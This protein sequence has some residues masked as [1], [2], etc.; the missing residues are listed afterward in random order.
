MKKPQYNCVQAIDVGSN[1]AWGVVAKKGGRGEVE[2][3][4]DEERITGLGRGSFGQKRLSTDGMERAEQAIRELVE[5][6]KRA[7]AEW[8]GAFGTS[9]LREAI[10]A[11]EFIRRFDGVVH[12][13]RVLSG[14]EE[15]MLAFEGA[16]MML[17]LV[18]SCA[19][20]DVG[21]GSTEVALGEAKVE[22]V[23]SLP[24][25]SLRLHEVF[26]RKQPLDDAEIRSLS[27]AIDKELDCAQIDSLPEVVAISGTAITCGCVARGYDHKDYPN[28]HGLTVER[29]EL[30][31]MACTF[32]KRRVEEVI[33]DRRVDPRRA[34]YFGVGAMILS[35]I[36]RRSKFERI[37]VSLGGLRHAIAKRV[38][39]GENW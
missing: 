4:V 28:V 11:D 21:G 20:V 10:N 38:L 2:V 32:L 1:A 15:G 8:V 7:G 14:E 27:A 23:W 16:R 9:A 35:R 19:V 13:F 17:N 31:E 29:E 33:S 26:V 30:D 39:D 37:R 18:G 12:R 3:M 6:G 36:A 24:L 25:G 5:R 22:K 34:P